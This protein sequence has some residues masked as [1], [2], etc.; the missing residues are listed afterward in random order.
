MAV[1]FRGLNSRIDVLIG[2]FTIIVGVFLVGDGHIIGPLILAI[3][4]LLLCLF[5]APQNSPLYAF[6]LRIVYF[7]LVFFAGMV[8]VGPG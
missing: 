7:A 4:G 2:I 5:T 1:I 6:A 3:A 8:I